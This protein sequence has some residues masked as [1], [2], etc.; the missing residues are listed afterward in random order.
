MGC[1]FSGA[2]KMVKSLIFFGIFFSEFLF[3][4]NMEDLAEKLLYT[5]HWNSVRLMLTVE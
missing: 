5:H 3:P 2:V 1:R 4:L